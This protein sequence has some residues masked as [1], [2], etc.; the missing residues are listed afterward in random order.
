MSRF[1]PDSDPKSAFS[2][3]NRVKVR[4]KSGPGGGVRRGSGL[5][6]QVRL[7]RLCSSSGEVLN[8]MCEMLA[9]CSD[10]QVDIWT[11]QAVYASSQNDLEKLIFSLTCGSAP[12][13]PPIARGPF[14]AKISLNNS[15]FKASAV[16]FYY[17][18]SECTPLSKFTIRSVVSTAGSFGNFCPIT[19]LTPN[20][21]EIV[22]L[23]QRLRGHKIAS[24]LRKAILS[25]RGPGEASQCR[26]ARIAAQ[27]PRNCPHRGGNFER[28]KTTH[29]CGG[30]VI[31]GAFKET[32][33][34]R[35]IASQE[36]D[37]RQ[38]G[39]NFCREARELFS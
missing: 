35:V 17:R 23:S 21:L 37:A 31:W 39:V 30:E 27:L 28:G 8:L 11:I 34:M 25:P 16:V 29:S 24:E 12:L 26:E 3:P 19:N 5:E 4:W 15:G 18:S 36:I 32:I 2:G 7:G 14:H 13:F 10:H 38:W 6:G 1:W 22:H 20:S 33:C 9:Y